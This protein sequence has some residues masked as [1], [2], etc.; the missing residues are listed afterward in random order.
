MVM[1]SDMCYFGPFQAWLAGLDQE[2]RVG[3]WDK[4]R[5]LASLVSMSKH[6]K[7]SPISLNTLDK[8]ECLVLKFSGFGVH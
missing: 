2:E 4:Y 8:G 7:T 6:F 1:T 5:L 3:I